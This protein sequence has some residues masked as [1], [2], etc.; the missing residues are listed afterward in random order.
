VVHALWLE[1][2]STRMLGTIFDFFILLRRSTIIISNSFAYLV[3]YY[4]LVLSASFVWL[5]VLNA[6][7]APPSFAIIPHQIGKGGGAIGF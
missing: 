4:F 6:P 2:S 3:S 7:P 1:G 5:S